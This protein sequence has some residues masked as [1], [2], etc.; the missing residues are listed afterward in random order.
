MKVTLRTILNC[1]GYFGLL[2][3]AGLPAVLIF[4]DSSARAVAEPACWQ[5]GKV[6]AVA[7]MFCC[8]VLPAGRQVRS[9]RTATE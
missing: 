4:R 2:L 8:L 5:A 9:A 6:N 3:T 1:H 7:V